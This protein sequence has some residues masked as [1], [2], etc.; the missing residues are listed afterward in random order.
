MTRLGTITALALLW[1]T[2]PACADDLLDTARLPRTA[3]AKEL[4]ANPVTTIFVTRQSVGESAQAASAALAR[5]GWQAYGPAFAQQ[6][7]RA[8]Q[9]ILSFKKGSIGLNVFV[10]VAPAQGN[11]TSVQYS[12]VK[13]AHDLPFPKDAAEVKFDPNR[14]HLECVTAESLGAALDFFRMELATRGWSPWTAP[15]A[16]IS[17]EKEATLFFTREGEKPLL[18]K[19]W[20]GEERTRVKIESVPASLLAKLAHPKN[21]PAPAPPQAAAP[22]RS[23]VDTA[24]EDTMKQAIQG[25]LQD[26][27]RDVKG[28]RAPAPAPKT[29]EAPLQAMEGGAPIPVPASA[30]DLEHDGEDR[31]LEFVAESSVAAVAAFYRA[32]MKGWKEGRSVINR[33]NM[34]VLDYTKGGK[35]VSLTIMQ[36]GPKTD[37]KARGSALVVAAKADQPASAATPTAP[38]TPV[39]LEAEE[40]GGLPVPSRST[41]K[42]T[43]KTPFRIT[44]T[45]TVSANRDSVL[46]FYRT[47]LGKRGWTETGSTSAQEWVVS[48]KAPEGPAQLRLTAKDM[49]TEVRLSLRK[50][51]EAEKAG[52]LPKAG[53]GKLVFGN[54]L[55]SEAEITVNKRTVKVGPGVGAKKPDG[56]MLDLAPGRYEVSFRSA[57]KPAQRETV[58]I[59]KD[60]TWGV[61]IGPGGALPLQ[62]Y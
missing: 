25:A 54:V 35:A 47:E 17:T 41:S 18:L 45:A 8:D 31:T 50:P 42:G 53:Q 43:E 19:L 12:G 5:E 1:L 32:Q 28:A 52:L 38:V 24:I 11:A 39:A 60:E 51:A 13:L 57:G 48:Y 58:T 14:P 36:M 26:A 56:P 61:L 4:F 23:A 2:A 49:D 55:D 46:A 44:L 37:V 40:M 9:K 21:E 15:G 30:Q 22:V 10:T 33:P 27:L 7:D 59:G 3:D 62:A 34:V 20:R 29:A 16:V 6:L